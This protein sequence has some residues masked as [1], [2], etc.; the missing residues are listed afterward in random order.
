MRFLLIL[1]TMFGICCSTSSAQAG[2]TI[3][4]VKAHNVV[5]CGSVERMGLASE[6]KPGVWSGL[7][8]D[9]CRAIA[10][11][12]LGSPDRIE[13][14]QYETDKDFDAVRKQQDDVYFLT[15]SEINAQKLAGSIVPG[16]TVFLESEAVM[17]ASTSAAQHVSDLSGNSICFMIGSSVER[18]LTAYFETLHKNWLRRAFSEDGEMIDTYN[19]QNCHAI[20]GE[21]TTLANIRLDS[22]VNRLSSRILPEFL[23]TFPII[24]AT[25]TQDAQWS[26]IVAWTVTT[27]IN[28]DRP[29]TR[30]YAGGVG[31]MPIL[32]P[33]LGLDQQWQRRIIASMGNYSKI[34]ERNLGK[35]SVLK[36]DQRLNANYFHGGLL[37]SPFLE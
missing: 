32:A 22:G 37:L 15:G 28:A 6:V 16:P 17:V 20:A 11:A 26:A 5:R 14:H 13:Y 1:L 8:V 4:R 35:G 33:E 21:V 19:V 30:W 3:K 12:V 27:L 36:L 9:V 34:F 31:V 29:E 23:S 24:A 25:G 18:S 7:N 2:S 10:A